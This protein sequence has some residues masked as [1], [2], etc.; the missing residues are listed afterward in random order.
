M[1]THSTRRG[2]PLWNASYKPLYSI[3][4]HGDLWPQNIMV[5]DSNVV[6]IIDWELRG[7]LNT[8]NLRT[9]FRVGRVIGRTMWCSPTRIFYATVPDGESC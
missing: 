9:L 5:K 7:I 8:G 3:H 6:A 1:V 2:F 4:A